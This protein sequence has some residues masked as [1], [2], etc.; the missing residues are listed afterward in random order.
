MIVKPKLKLI[1]RDG[2][3]FAI[4]GAAQSAARKAG[5][6]K[7]RIKQVMDEAQSSDYNHLL[8]TMMEYFDVH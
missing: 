3:A 5:W 4:L 1:G 7:E 6:D 2:N 8:A